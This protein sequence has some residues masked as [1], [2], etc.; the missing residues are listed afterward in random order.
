MSYKRLFSR[1]LAAAPERLHMA[2]HSHHLWPDAGREAQ[3]QVWD[4]AATLADHKWDRILGE[5]WPEAQG[6][7]ARELALPSPESVLFS[8]NTHDFL[9][10]LL[11]A[12]E[13]RPT[14]VLTTDGEFHSFR[15]QGARWVE[16]GA[17]ELDVVP[18]EPAAD[19]EERFLARAREGGHDLIF[20]SHVFF[21]TGRVF[22]RALELAEMARPEGPWV[23]LDGYHAFMAFPLD[24]SA[25]ADR[26]FYLGGGYKYAMSGEGAAFL[27]APPGFGARPEVTGW[28]AEFGRLS[29]P[30]GGVGYMSHGGRFMGA[31]F[32]AS[33]LYRFIAVRRMLDGEGLTT[34]TI[35]AHVAALQA[36]LV[37][38]IG[39]G[40]AGALG[41]A[42]LLNPL[43]GR[44]HAR[45]LAFRHPKAQAWKQALDARNVVTD[46]RDD[47]LRVGLALYHDPEDLDCFAQVCREA[48]G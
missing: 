5:V 3:L 31:T 17:V 9:I 22:H 2:A 13:R 7:V 23:V 25:V 46:V 39:S 6:H 44:A 21:Q 15:R 12:V 34:A 20:V 42:A 10:R 24:L 36:R 45:F 41:E 18:G 14:R 8:S 37:E 43:D 40:A 30:P 28:F 27:H 35:A 11:S 16:S 47:V 33:G 29:G 48:L 26:V 19:F 1:A 38:L 4:D 32:D